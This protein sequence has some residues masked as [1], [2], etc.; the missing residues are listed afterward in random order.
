MGLY[1]YENVY[2][3]LSGQ[4][5][6]SKEPWPYRDLTEWHERLHVPKG[7]MQGFGAHRLLWGSDFPCIMDDP[8]YGKMM[9]VVGELLPD[10][11]EHERADIMGGTAKRLLRF[12]KYPE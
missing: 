8:G 12:P 10:L 6:F 1:Q 9:R 2:V 11:S 7:R 3:H 5:A 4:Y